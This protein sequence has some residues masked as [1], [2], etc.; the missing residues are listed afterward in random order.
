MKKISLLL[1]ITLLVNLLVAQGDYEAFRFSQTDYQGTARYMGAGGAFSATGGEYSALSNNPASIGL[2]KRSEATIT[3]LAISF[4]TNN[5]MYLGN[6]TYT[7]TPKYTVPQS[8]LVITTEIDNSVWKAWQFGFGYNRIMDYNN[9]IRMNGANRS[10]MANTIINQANGIHFNNLEGDASLAWSTWYID[11]IPGFY[12][13]YYSPFTDKELQHDAL[14]KTTGSIDEIDFSFGGNFNDQLFIGGNLGFPFINYTERVDYIE[15]NIGEPAF[16]INEMQTSSYQKNSG[17]GVNL[18]LGLIYQPISFFRMGA[19]FQTPTYYWKIK[20]RY[21]RN[22]ITYYN[23]G[24]N[25][26]YWSY[27]NDFHFSL[28]TPLKFNISTAFLINKRAFISAEYEFMD[29]SKAILYANDYDFSAE[30]EAVRDKYGVCNTIRIGAEVNASQHFVLRAGYNFKSSPYKL[31]DS[32]YDATT[33]YGSAGFGIRTKYFFFDMAYVLRYS[34][35][36]YW[37]Y[38]APSGNSY[39]ENFSNAAAETSNLTH[40]IVATIGCKF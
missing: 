4:S 24:D 13:L 9:V 35:D 40:R 6:N 39:T 21:S 29:Y 36:S 2:F 19:S 25:S 11:T 22:M 37:V 8:G 23:D 33:H 7:Q 3:P 27:D 31:V 10:T 26:E 38:A 20:D 1:S 17:T 5:T 30:N 16:R 18:K 15:E 14:V 32:E 34:K 28:T 12:N